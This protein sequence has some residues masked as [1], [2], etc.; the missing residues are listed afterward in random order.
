M[1]YKHTQFGGWL[2]FL[3]VG[4]AVLFTGIWGIITSEIPALI[5][6][7]LFII[8]LALFYRLT[9]MIDEACL[10]VVYGIGLIRFKFSI[11]EIKSS[12]PVKNSWW[13][14]WGIRYT[15]HGW[16]FNIAGLQAVEFTLKD[17]R[18]FRIGTDEPEELCRALNRLSA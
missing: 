14:G 11:K 16:L 6:S 3:P 13:Y 2:I 5:L 9:V 17:N 12:R 1:I 10:R 15:P 18:T 4:I 7:V 8:I